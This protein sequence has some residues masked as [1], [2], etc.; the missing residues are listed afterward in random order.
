MD[1]D[2][3][4]KQVQE[5]KSEHQK[6][7]KSLKKKKLKNLDALFHDAH[8]AVFEKIDCL[9]C[10]N[11]CKTTSPIFKPRD[12]KRIS[13]HFR[14]KEGKFIDEYL[15]LDEEEDYVLKSSPCHFLDENNYCNIYE[16]RPDACREFPHTN[17]RKMNQILPLTATNA[18]M[19]P[20]VFEITE[21]VKSKL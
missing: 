5:H 19:C 8:D 10:A 12:I 16:I 21:I 4:H 13:K 9:L 15:F 14:M 11:C 1:L 6:F 3:F 7:Y 2:R 20:A 18:T 17:R